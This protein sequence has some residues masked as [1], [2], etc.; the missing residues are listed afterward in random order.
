M[1]N[2]YT[3][4][5]TS[6]FSTQLKKC[7]KSLPRQKIEQVFFILSASPFN[8][9]LRTHKVQS[10][11][12]GIAYS[13]SVTGNIRIIWNIDKTNSTIILLDIGTHS[14]SHKVYK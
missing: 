2:N 5:G 6:H 1:K 4:H 9:I 14:G 3:I 7:K 10:R 13:S 12:N 11:R 8:V